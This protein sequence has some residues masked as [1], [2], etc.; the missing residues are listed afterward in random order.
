MLTEYIRAAMHHAQYE[1]MENGRFFGKI[2]ECPG[3]WG[4]GATLEA[5]RDELESVLESW[6]ICG[7]RHGDDF[8]VIDDIDLNPKPDFDYAEADQAI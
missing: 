2:P 6:I 1:L 3:T 4:E 8:P 5:A 7:L